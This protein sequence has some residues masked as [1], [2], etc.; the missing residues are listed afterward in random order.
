MPG[1]G[2]RYH[3]T[4][5]ILHLETGRHL[6]GGARQ[7]LWLAQ[8]LAAR[9]IAN[10]ILCAAGGELLAA[11]RAAGLAAAALRVPSGWDAAC[12]R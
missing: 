6:Y 12:T 1:L 3:A 2:A 10:T 7:V 5:H 4:M 8:G 9:G 11:A